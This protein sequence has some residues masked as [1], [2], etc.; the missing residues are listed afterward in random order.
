M[1]LCILCKIEN[2]DCFSSCDECKFGL[3]ETCYRDYRNKLNKFT[4]EKIKKCELC[5]TNFNN[6]CSSCQS[7]TIHYMISDKLKKIPFENKSERTLLINLNKTYELK[8]DNLTID[9]KNMIG[10]EPHEYLKTH[11]NHCDCDNHLHC[12]NIAKDEFKKELG[13][14]DFN[15]YERGLDTLLC[16]NCW[17]NKYKDKQ[18]HPVI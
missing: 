13:I 8:W 3:C 7:Q 6:F 18:G 5:K 15:L 14:S 2:P 11:W 9:E 10:C 16:K 1:S 4:K 12:Y 17:V